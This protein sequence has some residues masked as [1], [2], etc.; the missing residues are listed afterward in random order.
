MNECYVFAEFF[1]ISRILRRAYRTE[2]FRLEPFDDIS[3]SLCTGT[4]TR[5]SLRDFHTDEQ[6]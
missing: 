6:N 1:V 5:A 2:Q 4:R 3:V